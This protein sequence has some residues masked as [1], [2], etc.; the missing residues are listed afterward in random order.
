[1][2]VVVMGMQGEEI[3]IIIIILAMAFKKR[4]S[5]V[6]VEAHKARWIGSKGRNRSEPKLVFFNFFR[7][8]NMNYLSVRTNK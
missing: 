7:R 4:M 8:K 1:M 5:D 2:I 6:T 3:I